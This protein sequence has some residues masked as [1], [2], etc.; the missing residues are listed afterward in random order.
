MTLFLRYSLILF[1]GFFFN[2][3]PNPAVSTVQEKRMQEIKKPPQSGQQTSKG[4]HSLG[5]ETIFIH[6]ADV[7]SQLPLISICS[8]SSGQE[9]GWQRPAPALG[10]AV[11]SSCSFPLPPRPCS[12]SPVAQRIPMPG[13]GSQAPA[14]FVA[15]MHPTTPAGASK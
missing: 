5:Y 4:R 14:G 12:H 9:P 3:C 1:M 13:K 2:T 8:L 10:D 15:V 6:P 7:L 11:L